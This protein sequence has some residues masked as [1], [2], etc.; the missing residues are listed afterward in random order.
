MRRIMMHMKEWIEKL[1]GF[2]ALNDKNIL[3]HAGNISHEMAVEV[4]ETEY[5]KFSKNRIALND[6]KESD[7][8]KAVKQVEAEKRRIKGK[9][10]KKN[11]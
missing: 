8:E 9:K 6:A 2:L 5:E 3:E 11:D 7:F 4:A 1:D 10:N